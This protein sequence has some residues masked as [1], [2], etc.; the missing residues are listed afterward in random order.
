M[1]HF[2]DLKLYR[3]LFV[4]SE[5]TEH[6]VENLYGKKLNVDLLKISV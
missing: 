5:Q 3:E 1:I 4:K 2:K 6:F